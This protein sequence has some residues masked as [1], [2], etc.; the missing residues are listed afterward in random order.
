MGVHSALET[1]VY[2]YIPNKGSLQSSEYL[3][4][5]R[6]DLIYRKQLNGGEVKSNS[7]HVV[8]P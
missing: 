3:C 4:V 8:S 2:R 1:T 6:L 7:F 5:V